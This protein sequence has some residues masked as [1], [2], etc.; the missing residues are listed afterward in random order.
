MLAPVVAAALACGADPEAAALTHLR[1]TH[2]SAK[3]EVVAA[4]F[5]RV[6]ADVL[7]GAP[8]ARA[9]GDA[10]GVAPPST[11]DDDLTVTHSKFG[12]A[13]Y[14]ESSWPVACHLVNKCA[15]PRR[16]VPPAPARRAK[17]SE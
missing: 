13:C 6:L 9:I 3:L 14:I 8:P 16:C 17:R 11:E 15:R 7:Q 5:A 12:P 10:A 1:T 4:R 2:D